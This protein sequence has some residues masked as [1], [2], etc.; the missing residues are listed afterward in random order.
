[1]FIHLTFTP[2]ISSSHAFLSIPTYQPT[3][4]TVYKKNVRIK[5][6]MTRPSRRIELLQD[7]PILVFLSSLYWRSSQKFVTNIY[8][9]IGDDDEK[10]TGV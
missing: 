9:R 3:L 2:L 8:Q 1:M 10:L 6:S 5:I 7:P 4:K